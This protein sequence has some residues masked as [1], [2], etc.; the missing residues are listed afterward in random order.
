MYFLDLNK[1]LLKQ[2]NDMYMQLEN[3]KLGDMPNEKII[4]TGYFEPVLVVNDG[5]YL[6]TEYL[7]KLN[8]KVYNLEETNR[9]LEVL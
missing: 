2:Y 3:C 5:N 6:D 4:K 7:L 1:D 9:I 8:N